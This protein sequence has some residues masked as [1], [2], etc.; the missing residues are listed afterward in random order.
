VTQEYSKILEETSQVEQASASFH[1]DQKIDIAPLV[2]L[3]ARHR[4]ENPDVGGAVK[5]GKPEDL[6]SSAS[7]LFDFHVLA[8]RAP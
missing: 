2:R 5:G 8:L 4:A 7:Q 3:T 6:G 1:I